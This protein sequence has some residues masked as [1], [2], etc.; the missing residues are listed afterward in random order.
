MASCPCTAPRP[1]CRGL[2]AL[3]CGQRALDEVQV[4]LL[5]GLGHQHRRHDHAQRRVG[6]VGGRLRQCVA[7]SGAAIMCRRCVV[8]VG[9]R[10][11]VLPAG[12][13]WK[14]PGH[15]CEEGPAGQRWRSAAG[16]GSLTCAASSWR[17]YCA[18]SRRSAKL[19]PRQALMPW[20][21]HPGMR[22]RARTDLE[23][24][25]EEQTAADSTTAA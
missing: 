11:G 19:R 4:C 14:G 1:A 10:L 15:R 13:C 22:R 2:P 3:T 16:R 20:S 25:G 17:T 24:P 7:H 6:A 23:A 21:L 18:S 8:A 12:S 9:V 5:Q